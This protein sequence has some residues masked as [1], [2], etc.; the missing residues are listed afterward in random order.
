[1]AE[2]LS[3][4]LPAETKATCHACPMLAGGEERPGPGVI[5][6][7]NK[8]KCC[9]YLPRLYNFLTGRILADDDPAAAGRTT[10][11]ARFVARMR[12]EIDC[13]AYKP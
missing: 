10:V 1:M 13:I 4:P 12:V 2:H 8:I 5:F 7:D 3:G 9:A 11:E 6:F